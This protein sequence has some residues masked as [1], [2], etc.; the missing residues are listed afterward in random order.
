MLSGVSLPET[1]PANHGAGGFGGCLVAC[2]AFCLARG[3]AH[4][5]AL[6]LASGQ[7]ALA[8]FAAKHAVRSACGA[9]KR[10]IASAVPHWGCPGYK[11]PDSA[12]SPVRPPTVQLLPPETFLPASPAPLALPCGPCHAFA[13]PSAPA[14]SRRATQYRR[15]L[16]PRNQPHPQRVPLGRQP[17]DTAHPGVPPRQAAGFPRGCAARRRALWCAA[18]GLCPLCGRA[19]PRV[20]VLALSC[21]N[22]PLHKLVINCLK[23]LQT[24]FKCFSNRSGIL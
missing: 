3:T 8:G 4:R 5:A 18:A 7:S 13:P 17:P 1:A 16:P 6:R 19:Y 9:P 2:L 14:F 22:R 20:S 15:H 12:R 21:H 24:H 23:F 11:A 10:Y